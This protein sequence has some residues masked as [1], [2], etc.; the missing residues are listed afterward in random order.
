MNMMMME[1]ME[2]MGMMMEMMVAL[3]MI[4]KQNINLNCYVHFDLYA[5][6]FIFFLVKQ[7][8]KTEGKHLKSLYK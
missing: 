4:N 1:M 8:E 7:Q 5:T 6:D 2:M 3:P